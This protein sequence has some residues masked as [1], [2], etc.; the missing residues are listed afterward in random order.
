MR[1]GIT[2]VDF[3]EMSIDEVELLIEQKE[4]DKKNELYQ[5]QDLATLISNRVAI[6][7][8]GDEIP[9]ITVEDIYPKLFEQEIVERKEAER[10][11][12]E[13]LHKAH[14]TRFAQLHNARKKKG[15]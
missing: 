10:K 8:Y 11:K 15:G 5:L 14:L 3:W 1:A 7:L 12:Q 9:L 2:P 13:E 6:S 4:I